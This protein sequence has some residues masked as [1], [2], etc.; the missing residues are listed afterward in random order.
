LST[1]GFDDPQSILDMRKRHAEIG[2]R[3]Q[4]LALHGLEE[5]E[6]K[7]ARGEALDMTADDVQKMLDVA[8]ELIGDR[9]KPI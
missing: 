1:P 4:R 5:S 3:M 8:A 9:K 2:M 7:V 6:A